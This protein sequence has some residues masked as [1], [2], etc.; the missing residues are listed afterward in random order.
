MPQFPWNNAH[1][2]VASTQLH[3][4]SIEGA[5]DQLRSPYPR[6]ILPQTTE[7]L[8]H[9]LNTFETAADKLPSFFLLLLFSHSLSLTSFHFH[10]PRLPLIAYGDYN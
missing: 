5:L 10:F 8:F 4:G 2:D 6:A 7:R 1:L 3:T 9:L